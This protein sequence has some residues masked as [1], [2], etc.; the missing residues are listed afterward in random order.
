MPPRGTLRDYAIVSAPPKTPLVG[1]SDSDDDK[2]EPLSV[3]N[4]TNAR[5]FAKAGE[6]HAS[7]APKTKRR[8][9]TT[10]AAPTMATD[11][12]ASTNAAAAPGTCVQ[13][14]TDEAASTNAAA[15]TD[16][17]VQMETGTCVNMP[18]A[19]ARV[20]AKAKPRAK[21][22][23]ARA[24]AKPSEPEQRS[25]E[26]AENN[27]L[28]QK[29]GYHLKK[30]RPAKF[31]EFK[32]LDW[33]QKRVWASKFRLG[34]TMAWLEA[35]TATETG[36]KDANESLI[37]WLTVDQIGGPMYL[38]NMQHARIVFDSGA[39]PKKPHE[40][41]LLAQAGVEVVRW[42]RNW[43]TL[44]DWRQDSTQ[45]RATG[46]MDEDTYT[47]VQDST[48]QGMTI[49]PDRT[50]NRTTPAEKHVDEAK[51]TTDEVISKRAS[52][53]HKSHERSV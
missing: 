7:D 14:A 50:P 18:R 23:P 2:Q 27:N 40:F 5:L 15:S 28:Y 53:D 11:E 46:E 52:D 26:S 12:A 17:C 36:V 25:T 42:S 10:K 49:A 19:P 41:D 21:T 37:E 16:T 4:A 33:A 13:M 9:A 24:K 8:R 32:Q 45:L 22:Q 47:H 39:L 6:G 35:T 3:G 43:K 29:M 38:N 48:L 31:D 30:T 1:I 51:K 34:P 20:A 44:S